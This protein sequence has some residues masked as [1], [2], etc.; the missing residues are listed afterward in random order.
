MSVPKLGMILPIL[1]IFAGCAMQPVVTPKPIEVPVLQKC[2]FPEIEAAKDYL[3]ELDPDDERILIKAGRAVIA[4]EKEQEA[5]ILRLRA[6]IKAC[7][8]EP[9]AETK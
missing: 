2:K 9:L 1:G 4:M 6:A 8:A 5:E 3:A 7:E